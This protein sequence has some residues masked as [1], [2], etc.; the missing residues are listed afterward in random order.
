MKKLLL[1]LFLALFLVGCSDD[2]TKDVNQNA[3]QEFKEGDKIT[4]KSVTG[5][6]LTIVRTQ[7]GFKIEN[8]DKILMIDIFGTF[9]VP[10]QTEAPHLMDFQL[11]NKDDFTIVGLIEYEEVANDYIIDNF[12]KKY[13]AYYFIANSKDNPNKAI[14]NQILK[15]LN[16]QHALSLPFKVIYNKDGILEKLTN[17]SKPKGEYFYLGTVKTSTLEEDFNRIKNANKN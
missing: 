14:I 12:V 10:C 9:C 7:K 4:L 5:N 2:A 3:N 6:D 13:N 17:F 1:A 15:D 8:S 16:Y 11:K